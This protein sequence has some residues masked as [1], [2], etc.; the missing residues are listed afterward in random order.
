MQQW[1]RLLWSQWWVRLQ[2]HKSRQGISVVYCS[3]AKKKL[4]RE[5]SCHWYFNRHSQNSWHRRDFWN[6]PRSVFSA[7]LLV[8][9]KVCMTW[10]KKYLYLFPSLLDWHFSTSKRTLGWMPCHRQR[11]RT[12]GCR[13]WCSLT[14]RIVSAPWWMM[15]PSS[16]WRGKVTTPGQTFQMWRTGSSTPG[17]RIRSLSV[18]FTTSGFFAITGFNVKIK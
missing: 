6:L 3:A 17:R 9:L 7:L 15:T 10:F 1:T 4:S 12:F 14:R 5:E 18:D 16:R 13:S 8:W 11:S 2:D